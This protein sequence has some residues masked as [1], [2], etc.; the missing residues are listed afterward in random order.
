[1]SRQLSWP[2]FI[3]IVGAWVLGHYSGSLDKSSVAREDDAIPV[4]RSAECRW[5]SGPIKIDGQV[6]EE[7]WSKA[8][9]L[10]NFV[11]YWAKRKPK[12]GTKARLLWDDKFLYFTAEMEDTDLYADVK[13][14]NGMTWTNDV[15]ELFFKPR[16]DRL[17]YYEFQV[18]AANT[19]LELFFPS[20]GSGGYQRFAPLTRLGMESAV[21]LDGTLNN[22]QDRDKGWTVE[23]RIPWTA[24]AATGG[25]PKPGNKW[26]FSLCR[27]DYSAAFDRPE[28][29]S[30]SPLTVSDFH[31]YEDFGELTFVT[32]ND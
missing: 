15:F 5:V 7:A 18:N 11:A 2:L 17:A 32:P 22:W 24:F 23:G 19:P 6:D 9:V 8:Q 25:K 10:Q 1:M 12:T 28:L 29:S 16:E 13:E 14:R 27:Y 20:R 3:L 26:R 4:D 31:R 21:K 30:T